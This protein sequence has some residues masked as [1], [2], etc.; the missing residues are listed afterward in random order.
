MHRLLV[1]PGTILALSTGL[2][3]TDALRAEDEKLSA[4]QKAQKARSAEPKES[5]VDKT[6]SLEG[7]LSKKGPSDWSAAKAAVIEGRVVQVERES[8]DGDY[9][10]TLSP[11]GGGTDTTKWVITEV[12]PVWARKKPALSQASLEKLRGK[13]VRVTGWLFYEPE[14]PHRDPRGTRWEI[15]PV[16][17]VAV[18]GN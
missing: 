8:D 1:S 18:V 3:F 11:A 12:T 15:H 9:H 17:D 10:L 13:T 5:D 6:V 7:L 16:T 2:L 14:D 4:E